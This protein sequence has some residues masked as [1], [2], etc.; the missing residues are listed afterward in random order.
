M[1]KC[2]LTRLPPKRAP[3]N[4]THEIPHLDFQSHLNANVKAEEWARKGV[5]YANAGKV[6]QARE[7]EKKAMYWLARARKMEPTPVR[8]WLGRK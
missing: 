4:R 6:K 2:K 5:A 8:P 7:C 1:A 3:R